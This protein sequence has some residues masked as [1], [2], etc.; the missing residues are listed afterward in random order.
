MYTPSSWNSASIVVFTALMALADTVLVFWLFNNA[1]ALAVALGGIAGIVLSVAWAIRR[2]LPVVSTGL[3]A[4]AVV[5][6]ISLGRSSPGAGALSLCAALGV[7]AAW[8]LAYDVWVTG[9]A[10]TEFVSPLLP[11]GGDGRAGHALI[12]YH[13]GRGSRQFQRRLQEALAEA[14]QANDWQVDLTTA[15]RQTPTDVSRYDLLVLGAQTYNWRP[16]R[17]I[18]DY[19]ERV[20]DLKGTPVVLVVSGW[21]MTER[22]MRT[23]QIRVVEA[24]GVIADEIEVWTSRPN[25]ERHGLSDP[26]AVMRRAAARLALVWAKRASA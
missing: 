1:P 13:R 23:L 20:G 10:N 22:A 25:E 4:T 21:G 16:A 9:R 14:L 11:L 3:L 15:S 7:W 5:L 6:I 26:E 19:I 18:V 2:Y 8:F 12:V 24:G 17:P